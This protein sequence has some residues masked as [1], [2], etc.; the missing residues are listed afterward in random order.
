VPALLRKLFS[1]PYNIRRKF[2]QILTD[3]ELARKV[4][5]DR[6]FVI[7]H[8]GGIVINEYTKIAHNR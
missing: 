6:K 5:I 3:V 4:Q 8:F 1:L 7:D 2:I